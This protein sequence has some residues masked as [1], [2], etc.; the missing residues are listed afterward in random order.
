M[1]VH[2]TQYAAVRDDQNALSG[3]LLDDGIERL[4][5]TSSGRL[6]RLEIGRPLVIVEVAGPLDADFSLGQTLPFAGVVF[7]PSDVESVSIAS[8]DRGNGLSGDSRSFEVA[9]HHGVE[10]RAFGGDESAGESGLLESE[11]RQ[12]RIGLSLPA[13]AGV[14]FTLSVSQHQN[15]GSDKFGLMGLGRLCHR[16]FVV[17]TWSGTT[18]EGT[19]GTLGE[20]ATLR[21][22]A[23]AREVA[24]TSSDTVEGSTVDEVIANATFRYGQNFADLLPTC[25]IWLNG[26]AVPN[27][28][29]VG[30]KDEVA[31]LPPVS[32][33][34][35]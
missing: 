16:T 9:R 22:F 32:G 27:S 10:G 2:E 5:S 20:V 35:Q 26:E 14:P 12:W 3:I 6:D 23:R 8:D 4:R 30:D 25:R 21:L 15:S 29:P 11:G 13:P 28:T 33:G 18:I 7:A 24:G 31:V 34:F 1:L 17:F 19:A